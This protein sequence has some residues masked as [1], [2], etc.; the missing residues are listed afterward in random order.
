M[1]RTDP[2]DFLL[3]YLSLPSDLQLLV[4]RR[5]VYNVKRSLS[6]LYKEFM[7]VNSTPKYHV[8]IFVLQINLNSLLNY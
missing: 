5:E 6:T 2:P 4:I 7:R 1:Q 3:A 8:N